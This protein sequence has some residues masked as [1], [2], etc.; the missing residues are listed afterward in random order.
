MM[1]AY[2][3]RR[4]GKTLTLGLGK[5][6]YLLITHKLIYFFLYFAEYFTAEAA[7]S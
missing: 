1:R 4:G 3:G 7:G 2:R 5:R 6:P